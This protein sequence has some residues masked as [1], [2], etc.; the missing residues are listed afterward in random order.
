MARQAM[1]YQ[2]SLAKHPT[3]EPTTMPSGKLK[4]KLLDPEGKPVTGALRLA[5]LRLWRRLSKTPHGGAPPTRNEAPA[6][7]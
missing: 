6:E 1:E 3:T 5:C 2:D 7:R 4:L